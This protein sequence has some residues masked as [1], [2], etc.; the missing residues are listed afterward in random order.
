[1]CGPSRDRLRTL[2]SLVRKLVVWF[3]NNPGEEFDINLIRSDK[4][5]SG[6]E[7]EKAG[8]VTE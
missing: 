5:S 7:D 8:D 6:D 2:N 1:M 4:D 3:E